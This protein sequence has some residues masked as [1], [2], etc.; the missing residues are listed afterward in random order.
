M[1]FS[2]H[3]IMTFIHLQLLWILTDVVTISRTNKNQNTGE[4]SIFVDCLVYAKVAGHCMTTSR[5]R[6]KMDSQLTTNKTN[7]VLISFVL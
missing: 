7:T 5:Y 4:W 2:E 1:L 6:F 3:P